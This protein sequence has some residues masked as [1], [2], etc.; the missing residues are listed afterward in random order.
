MSKNKS[1]LLI[2]AGAVLVVLC[3]FLPWISISFLGISLS[4]SGI[5][6]ASGSGAEGM[7]ELSSG[8]GSSTLLY[9]IPALAFVSVIVASLGSKKMGSK[10]AGITGII[11]GIIPLA[12]WGYILMK[13]NQSLSEASKGAAE[14]GIKMGLMNVVGI[15]F[16][17][18]GL[19]LILIVVGGL[20][21][22]KDKGQTSG[23]N[24]AAP[25]TPAEPQAPT[26]P[27]TPVA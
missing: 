26:E 7:K 4:V 1:A 17:G 8:L 21:M 16:W 5:N 22:L 23:G 12:Y 2:Y 24:T 27:Q 15:G 11:S 25:Q 9:M 14:L 20:L 3:F 19:G 10:N 6:L 13:V 18:T